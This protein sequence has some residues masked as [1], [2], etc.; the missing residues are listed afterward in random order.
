VKNERRK[1]GVGESGERRERERERAK[2]RQEN[3]KAGESV[4]EKR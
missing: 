1:R 3:K 4:R 2:K